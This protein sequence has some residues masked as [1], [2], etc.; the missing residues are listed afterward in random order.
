MV[1]RSAGNVSNFMSEWTASKVDRLG[2]Q[3]RQRQFTPA[4]L[5]NLD[6]YRNSFVPAYETAVSR[7]KQLDYAVTGRP[8]K[9]TAALVDKLNRQHVRLSQVQDIAGCRVIVEDIYL[10][11]RAIPTLE[12]FLGTPAIYDRRSQSSHGYRA[13][14]LV[15]TVGGRKVEIQ[16]RTELQHLWAEISEKLADTVDPRIKYGDGDKEANELLANLSLA[17]SKVEQ[18]EVE[19]ARAFEL[20]RS[21]DAS[22]KKHFKKAIRSAERNFFAQRSRVIQLLTDIHEELHRKAA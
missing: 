22:Q 19:R 3:L 20:L 18:E 10:Q 21:A 13:V 14:H 8:A 15:A 5:V 9:S 6:S 16:L 2:D 12:V 7:L 1:I 11:N 4:L 17:I